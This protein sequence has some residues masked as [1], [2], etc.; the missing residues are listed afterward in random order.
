MIC[1]DLF[2]VLKV[3]AFVLYS[4]TENFASND[5]SITAAI[6]STIFALVA[7]LE[8]D[9]ISLRTKEALQVKKASGVKLG[10]PKGKKGKSKL[11]IH[12]EKRVYLLG[13]NFP[14]T[15]IARECGTTV[16]NLYNYL[17]NI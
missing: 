6:T 14:K 4:L 13:L 17:K 15:V 9:L 16:S 3:L 8:R 5:K 1:L 7:Q 2:F 12:R 10:R 11:D